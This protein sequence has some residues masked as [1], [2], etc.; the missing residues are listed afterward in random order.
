MRPG[1]TLSRKKTMPDPTKPPTKEPDTRPRAVGKAL[2]AWNCARWNAGPPR[3]AGRTWALA[4]LG[5][6]AKF[7]SLSLRK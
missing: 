7:E 2:A 3:P 6:G 1:R 4:V 5:R